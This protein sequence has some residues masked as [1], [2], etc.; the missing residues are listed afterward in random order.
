MLSFYIP[1]LNHCPPP[2]TPSLTTRKNCSFLI[3]THHLID[4][5]GTHAK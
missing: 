5:K 1:I 2:L 3:R 4:I